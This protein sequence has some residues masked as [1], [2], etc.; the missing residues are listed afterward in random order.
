MIEVPCNGC[1]RCCIG[2]AIR[3]LDDEDADHYLTVPHP[4][5][6]GKRMLA[7]KPDNS[8]FYLGPTGCTIHDSKPRLCRD[9]DCRE[10]GKFS[11]T[12]ARRIKIIPI[13]RK[14]RELSE[15]DHENASHA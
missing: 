3:L 14:G 9:F 10:I 8:C 15:A 12:F 11:F 2:D 5:M 13:W 4:N 6:P 1:V 7:H